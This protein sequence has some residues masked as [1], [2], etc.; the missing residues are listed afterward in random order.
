M[1]FQDIGGP[2][3]PL[4]EKCDE[5]SV[6]AFKAVAG[7]EFGGGGR[8]AGSGVEQGDRDLASAEGGVENGNI[9]DDEGDEPQ[10]GAAF[11]DHEEAG[12]LA[13][14]NDVSGTEGGERRAAD[15][16][17]GEEAGAEMLV[18]G[19][20]RILVG[21]AEAVEGEGEAEG[22]EGG[23]EE[24]K[25][26]ERERS[27]D[28]I[29][30]FPRFVTFEA[31]SKEDPG[32]PGEDEEEAGD[33]QTAAGA[34][35]NDDSLNG[36]CSN[37]TAAEETKEDCEP[38]HESQSPEVTSSGVVRPAS[39]SIPLRETRGCPVKAQRDFFHMV[40]KAI[41]THAVGEVDLYQSTPSRTALTP[42]G[43]GIGWN[44]MRRVLI[45][46]DE[47]VVADTLR[48]IF[49]KNGF[50]AQSVYSADEA[51]LRAE[52]FAPELMLCDINMPEKDGVELISAMTLGY[53][54]CRIL[55]LT[56]AYSSI[57][58]VRDFGAKLKRKLPILAKPCAPAE[59]LREAGD[60]LLLA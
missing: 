37:Q 28:A 10:A 38:M 21:R 35:G 53:P 18:S 5:G 44:T 7:Q 40:R 31:L 12:D 6:S 25:K 2:A 4:G 36:V 39:M 20:A 42:G 50:E 16:D 51:M 27:V 34:P 49:Q 3:L 48:L 9:T 45:V 11:E 47:P 33:A 19:Q 32:R 43:V 1:G 46:D 26:D 23:P 17:V 56:G 8:G 13:A 24:Q 30:L 52:S 22:Q 57:A 60:L 58:R 54:A 59:L 41:D 15:V 14:G 29:E 55:V